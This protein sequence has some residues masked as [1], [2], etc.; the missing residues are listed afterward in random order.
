M[1]PEVKCRD[2]T[3]L[4]RRHADRHR[5]HDPVGLRPS[6]DRV[7]QRRGGIYSREFAARCRRS[8]SPRGT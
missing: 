6:R 4:P 2:M 5:R 3:Q 8:S 1:P 7:A